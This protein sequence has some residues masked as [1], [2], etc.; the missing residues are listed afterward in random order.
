MKYLNIIAT[1][2]LFSNLSFAQSDSIRWSPDDG[3]RKIMTEEQ[4]MY[5]TIDISFV[6]Y[7]DTMYRVITY[8]LINKD[9]CNYIILTKKNNHKW[10]YKKDDVE[11]EYIL[12]RCLINK[13][14]FGKIKGQRYKRIKTTEYH[15][16]GNKKTYIYLWKFKINRQG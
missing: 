5:H 6:L 7:N 12:R 1:S 14:S 13:K 4:S 3:N 15:S 9:T 16:D 2:I 11:I 8:P 10:S